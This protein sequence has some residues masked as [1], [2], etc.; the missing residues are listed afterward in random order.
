M[1]IGKTVI[2]KVWERKED[3]EFNLHTIWNKIGDAD[4][5]DWSKK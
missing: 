3:F 1:K 5:R 2:E 4:I